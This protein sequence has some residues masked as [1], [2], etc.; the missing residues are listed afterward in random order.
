M[1]L[2]DRSEWWMGPTQEKGEWTCVFQEIGTLFVLT[3]GEPVRHE[4]SAEN[5]AC[6]HKE[7]TR[8]QTW[9]YKIYIA[10]IVCMWS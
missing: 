7:V 3:P 6:A 4:L 1:L 8:Y 2:K 9:D 10:I 5:L